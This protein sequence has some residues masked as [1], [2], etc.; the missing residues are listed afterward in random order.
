MH[1]IPEEPSDEHG[2]NGTGGVDGLEGGDGGV[3]SSED[4]YDGDGDVKESV[5]LEES[6]VD[7]DEGGDGGGS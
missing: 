5:V 3:L 7:S 1:W 6:V 2:P 4:C